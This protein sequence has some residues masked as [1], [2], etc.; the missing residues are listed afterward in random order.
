MMT[1][2]KRKLKQKILYFIWPAYR[3]QKD[4]ET[5]AAIKWLIEHPEAPCIIGDSYIPNGYGTIGGCA[6]GE[7]L[8]ARQ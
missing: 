4:A 3:R 7:P 5:K 1:F 2:R 6:G 8:N